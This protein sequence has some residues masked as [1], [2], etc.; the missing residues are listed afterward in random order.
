MSNSNTEE[1]LLSLKAELELALED[2]NTSAA[3]VQLDQNAVGRLSRMD[4]MQQQNMALANKRS[5]SV[6]LAKTH[7]ALSA[8]KSGDYGFC[9]EC[10]EEISAGRLELYPESDLCIRCQSNRE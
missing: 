6:R 5:L 3:T 7:K 8:I 1:T 10:G 9:E 2:A 4:A